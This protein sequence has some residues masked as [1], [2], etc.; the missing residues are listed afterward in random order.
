MITF[1]RFAFCVLVLMVA[2]GCASAKL[3]EREARAG[4]KK[5]P[6]PERIYVYPFAAT[7]ADIPTWSAAAK[8]YAPPKEPPTP[9]AL[10]YARKLGDLIAKELIDNIV[11]MGLVAIPGSQQSLPRN[12]DLMIIGYFEAV[13]KGSTVKRMAVGFGSG[14][15]KL[16]TAVE[17]YQM[18]ST[19]PR[20]L[21]S[22]NVEYEGGKTPGLFV[23]A[24]MTAATGSPIGLIIMTGVKVYGETSGKTEIEGPAK[25]TAKAI[26][27]LIRVK[28]KKFGWIQ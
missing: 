17:G 2:V 18:T 3:T 5:L 28:F 20:L 25:D 19:G 8:R 1:S 16:T 13:E 26:A 15:A 23:P 4:H 11:E 27:D 6:R 14:K 10:E 22:G 12:N 7:P 24:V 21:G 9:E